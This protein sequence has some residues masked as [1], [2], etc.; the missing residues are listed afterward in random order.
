MRHMP[1]L[2]SIWAPGC[3]GG[4]W[5]RSWPLHV[6]VHALQVQ[7]PALD[8]T[9]AVQLVGPQ[10]QLPAIKHS[11]WATDRRESYRLPAMRPFL[12]MFGSC[13]V[14]CKLACARAGAV[15]AVPIVPL[16]YCQK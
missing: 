1:W 16:A 7:R 13:C 3:Y 8:A 15:S 2:R 4:P 5:R 12:Y 11:Q 6:V 10:R 14:T 9:I